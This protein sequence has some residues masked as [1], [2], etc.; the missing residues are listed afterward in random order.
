MPDYM[1]RRIR[2]LS[3]KTAAKAQLPDISGR[4]IFP[5]AIGIFSNT[6][7]IN[8]YGHSMAVS[9]TYNPVHNIYNQPDNRI[10]VNGF[11]YIS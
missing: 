1:D 7:K 6:L 4:Y 9:M 5:I 2:D 8:I 10:T 11:H 3:P